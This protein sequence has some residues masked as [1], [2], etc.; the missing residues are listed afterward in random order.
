MT[1]SGGTAKI[2]FCLQPSAKDLGNTQVVVVVLIVL[3]LFH[4]SHFLFNSAS[5]GI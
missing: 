2:V 1:V 4:L 3:V 5:T